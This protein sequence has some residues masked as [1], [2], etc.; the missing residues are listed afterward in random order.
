MLMLI[1][2]G[3]NGFFIGILFVIGHDC[4]HGSFTAHKWLNQLLGRLAF[5]PNLHLFTTWEYSH[6]VLHHSYTNVRNR[7]N[8]YVPFTFEQFNSLPT[9]RRTL[10]RIYRSPI[11]LGLFYFL[12]HYL[13]YEL[14]PTR[15]RRSPIKPAYIFHMDRLLVAGFLAIQISFLCWWASRVGVSPWK[16]IVLGFVIPYSFWTYLMGFF[17][18][19]MHTHPLV[20]WYADEED[21]SFFRGQIRGTP[22]IEFPALVDFILHNVMQHT[23]HHADQNIPL[24]NLR[25]SQKSLET[26]YGSDIVHVKWNFSGFVKVMRTCRLFDYQGHRWLDFDGTPK[27]PSLTD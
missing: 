27:S 13:R 25:R 14:F 8:A 23:A 19:Q 22:H 5:L 10:E 12:E 20:P 17:T 18:F 4:C 11:G 2:I 7:D 9:W 24:Y 3:I 1:Y 26:A 6:N 21:W 16:F 15:A